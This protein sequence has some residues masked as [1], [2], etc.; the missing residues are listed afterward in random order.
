MGEFAKHLR[1][2][3]QGA[4]TLREQLR[5]KAPKYGN[6]DQK[7]DDLA[8]WVAET[9]CDI[10][11]KYKARG[12]NG[13]Y[14]PCMVSAA[15]QTME[16]MMLGATPDGRCQGEPV[17]NGMSPVNGM[18]RN[19]LTM[20]LRSVAHA[21]KDA[22][23]TNGT[24]FNI[25]ISPN[26]IQTEEGLD[27]FASVIEAYLELGGRELQI[28]PIDTETLRDAQKHPEKYPDLSVKVTGYSARFIDL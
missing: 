27:R 24:T 11:R 4:E 7:T 28:N 25:R 22:L 8:K 15:T 19:G 2:N 6:G 18:E 5:N 14:H 17:A 12:G 9:L 13:T 1:N 21:T 23:L 16:G 3:F 26:M 20:T 10:T